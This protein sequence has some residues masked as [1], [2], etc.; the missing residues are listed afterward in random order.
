[1]TGLYVHV[2]F[3]KSKC[4]YCDFVS[5]VDLETIPRYLEALRGEALLRGRRT[6]K[7]ET[8]YV[9]GGTPSVFAP[10]QLVELF[11]ILRE[12]F[13]FIDGAEVTVELNPDDVDD[14]II[15]A[16]HEVGVN[17]LSLGVQSLDDEVLRFLGR[18]HTSS[19]AR[20]AIELTR[21]QSWAE[22]SLDV[23]Y[24]WHFQSET[25][26]LDT[27][28]RILS[29]APEHLSC[30]QLTVEGDNSFAARRAEGER[31]E[32]DEEIGRRLF[33]LTH[34]LL[35]NAG[36]EHYEVSSYARPGRRSKHNQSYWDHVAYVGLG[37]SAH[38]FDGRDRRS[39]NVSDLREYV[40]R[41]LRSIDVT[42]DSERLTDEQ[43]LLERLLLGFRTAEGVDE[44]VL[45][46][47]TGS[48]EVLL[49]LV[50]EGLCRREDGRVV[51]TVEGLLVADSLP[52]RFELL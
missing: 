28:E 18:R 35:T 29:Y 33:L 27:L 42:D 14:E 24:G 23:M 19:Q 43:L 8:V 47:I 4:Q 31:L 36:Y 52:L 15:D 46:V 7:V 1:M 37:P 13:D 21:A 9:G 22:L 30:Y 50:D 39:W 25:S 48:K 26:H 32:V 44:A 10:D 6:A 41:A 40:D 51:T 12:G 11:A 20:R 16:L 2:P 45:S 17:R 49:Q 3:C 5:F 38:S 34:D